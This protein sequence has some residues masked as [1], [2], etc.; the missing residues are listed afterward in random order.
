MIRVKLP[1]GR[2]HL[3]DTDD[4]SV[5][6]KEAREFYKNN[7][8]PLQRGA[9]FGEE[10]VSVLG[11]MARGIGAGAIGAWAEMLVEGPPF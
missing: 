2:S 4:E 7:P 5:A 9:Q 11:D 1:D 10:D 8:E 6:Q 3:V